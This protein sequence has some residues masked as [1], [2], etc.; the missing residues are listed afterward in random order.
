LDTGLKKL[1][2]SFSYFLKKGGGATCLYFLRLSKGNMLLVR[3]TS[4]G[5][6]EATSCLLRNWK[7]GFYKPNKIPLLRSWFIKKT[8]GYWRAFARHFKRMNVC[9][10]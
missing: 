10:K 5:W 3:K 4:F 2:S 6:G 7:S 1:I 8:S 9:V